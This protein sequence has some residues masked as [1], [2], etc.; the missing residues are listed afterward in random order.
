LLLGIDPEQTEVQALFAVF[1]A[2]VVDEGKPRLPVGIGGG[3]VLRFNRLAFGGR[4]LI[5]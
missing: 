1:A 4:Q 3:D 5:R 2:V